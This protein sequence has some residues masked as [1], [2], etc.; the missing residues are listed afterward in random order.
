MAN[1]PAR[2]DARDR[3]DIL[4]NAPWNSMGRPSQVGQSKLFGFWAF[5]RP[6][7]GTSSPRNPSKSARSARMTRTEQKRRTLPLWAPL[8][9]ARHLAARLPC[10]EDHRYRRPPMAEGRLCSRLSKGGHR[11][12]DL[13]Q[14]HRPRDRTPLAAAVSRCGIAPGAKRRSGPQRS[15]PDLQQIRVGTTSRKDR[16]GRHWP[17]RACG[18]A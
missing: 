17:Y 8:K 9:K 6:L 4:K 3:W 15:R 1:P 5:L 11:V 13:S 10:E 16:I 2:H 14:P 7:L 12:S 18:H